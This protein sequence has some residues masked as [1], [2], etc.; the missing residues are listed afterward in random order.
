MCVANS[1]TY[2]YNSSITVT[3]GSPTTGAF[4]DGL[5]VF[6]VTNDST[7]ANVKPTAKQVFIIA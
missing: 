2:L 4:K 3:G 6:W 1:G 5:D 7:W